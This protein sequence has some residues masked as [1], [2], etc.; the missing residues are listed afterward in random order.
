VPGPA[1]TPTLSRREIVV[2]ALACGIT[3]ANVYFAQA[4]SPLV[5]ATRRESSCWC[6]S[7]TGC[8]TGHCC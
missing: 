1:T 4:V 3:V 6:R 5:G 8:R 7:V 2:L